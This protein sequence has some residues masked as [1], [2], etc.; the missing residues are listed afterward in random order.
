MDTVPDMPGIRIADAEGYEG[1]EDGHI[2]LEGLANTRDL[3]GK[4]TLDG[5]FVARGR[6]VRSGEL[7]RQPPATLP[8]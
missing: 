6:L 8:C 3:G 2:E 7:A 4:P 1:V 5:R